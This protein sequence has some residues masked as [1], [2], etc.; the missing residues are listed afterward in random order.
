MYSKMN[1]KANFSLIAFRK[2]PIR[3]SCKI[4]RRPCDDKKKMRLWRELEGVE[5]GDSRGLGEAEEKKGVL[6]HGYYPFYS[7]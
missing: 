7:N 6:G 2:Q 1:C 5:A 3:L 4:P